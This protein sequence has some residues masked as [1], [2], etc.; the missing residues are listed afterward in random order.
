MAS[1]APLELTGD[2]RRELARWARGG[3][4]RSRLTTRARIVLA[5]AGG[6]PNAEVARRLGVSAA[7]VGKWRTRYLAAGLGGLADGP[8]SGRPRTRRRECFEAVVRTLEGRPPEGAPRWSTRRMAATVGVSQSTVSR[9]WRAVGLEPHRIDHRR[10]RDDP[11]VVVRARALLDPPARPG[12]AT[13]P[14]PPAPSRGDLRSALDTA[15][16]RILRSIESRPRGAE[17]GRRL[18]RSRSRR[19]AS[20]DGDRRSQ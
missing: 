7:T 15:G 3:R 12:P 20:G 19:S 13:A 16:H 14:A 9:T 6:A 2:E 11:R 10:L 17:L 4:A 8:R 18:R 5:C 1:I